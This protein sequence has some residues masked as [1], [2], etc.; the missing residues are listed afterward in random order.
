MEENAMAT[1]KA[2]KRKVKR[3]P[4][5]AAKEVHGIMEALSGR[6]LKPINSSKNQGKKK[7]R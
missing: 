6:G 3:L 7:K 4:R 1:M 2:G 5:W